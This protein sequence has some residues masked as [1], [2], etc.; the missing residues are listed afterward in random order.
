MV[1]MSALVSPLESRIRLDRREWKR[2]AIYQ[3]AFCQFK[4]QSNEEVFVSGHVVNISRGGLK[5]LSSQRIEPGTAFRI[6]IADGNDGLFT[7]LS[8]RVIYVDEAPDHKWFL[9]CTFTPKLRQDI[10][11]WVERIGS[12]SSDNEQQPKALVAG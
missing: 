9:G 8:S 2:T 12:A 3:E 10:L 5:M 7:L 11:L 1:L 4:N 6:G